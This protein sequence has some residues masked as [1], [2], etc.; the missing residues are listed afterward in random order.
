MLCTRTNQRGFSLVELMLVVAAAGTIMAIALPVMTGLTA[1]TKVNEAARLIEREYQDARLRAVAS[2]RMLRVRTNCP[3]AGYVR[4]VEVLNTAVDLA[5]NRCLN[6]AFPFPADA[7]LM[8]RPNYDGPV[9]TIPNG[10][11][12][13][14]AVIE[15]SPDGT[16]R[17][18]VAGVAE[19]IATAQTITITRQGLSRTVTVNAAGKVQLQ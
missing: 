19:P 15:F 11:T 16:A 2:N 8:T 12:A 18:V 9:R 3:S 6:S 10:A 7:D 17:L 13:T 4:T 14:T 1:A 5:S